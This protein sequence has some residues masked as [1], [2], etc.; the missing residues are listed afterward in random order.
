M[1]A[2]RAGEYKTYLVERAGWAVL[3]ALASLGGGA[4]LLLLGIQASLGIVLTVTIAFIPAGLIMC[5]LRLKTRAERRSQLVL[6]ELPIATDLLCLAVTAGES[7]RSA[8]Q[9]V[10][11][12]VKGPLSTEL[13]FVI[14]G[15][16]S[17]ISLEQA[18]EQFASRTCLSEVHRLVDAITVA[19]DRGIPLAD[20]LSVLA[21][22]MR[23][24]Q[25]RQII[26]VA[27]KRQI[28][29]L[30]PV[31]GL[32]LPTTLLFAFFPAIVSLRQLVG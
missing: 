17:G 5:D 31:V 6:Q 16:K 11:V 8:L 12:S 14:A 22:E 29:M 20:S 3:G 7:L 1:K 30:I 26:D 25:R 4:G 18:L 13:R 21:E 9:R 27:G 2:G 15:L 32:I 24:A 28:T 10:A 23:E 19:Q